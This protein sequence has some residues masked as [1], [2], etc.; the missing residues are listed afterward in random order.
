MVSCL[1]FLSVLLVLHLVLFL[2]AGHGL[3]FVGAVTLASFAQ[4]FMA[5]HWGTL[6]ATGLDRVASPNVSS[7]DVVPTGEALACPQPSLAETGTVEASSAPP[8]SLVL[9]LPPR[10]SSSTDVSPVKAKKKGAHGPSL[11]KAGFHAKAR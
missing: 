9:P 3:G 1:G 7:P 2:A 4:F 10:A 11:G 8:P 5:A 6:I